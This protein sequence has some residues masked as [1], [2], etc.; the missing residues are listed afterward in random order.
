MNAAL[1]LDDFQNDSSSGVVYFLVEL[2]E[3]IERNIAET[4]YDR[5]EVF[6]VFGI[7]SGAHCA[8]SATVKAAHRAD[9][10]CFPRCEAGKLDRGL[11]GF[12]S[13]VAQKRAL[14]I[15]RRDR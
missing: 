8:H 10:I 13:G 1:A 6:A 12:R 3:V 9:E 11:D 15:F 2:L 5:L 7:K 14:E 4:R